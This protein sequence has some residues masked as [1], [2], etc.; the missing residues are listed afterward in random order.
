MRRIEAESPGLPQ[1]VGPDLGAN[2]WLIDEGVVRGNG[3]VLPRVRVID[4]DA[5]DLAEQ[6]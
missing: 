4:V 6:S 2:A 5:K 1:A 3:I